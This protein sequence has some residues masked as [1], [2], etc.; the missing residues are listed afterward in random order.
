MVK[1]DFKD[2]FYY[3]SFRYSDYVITFYLSNL[4]GVESRQI[5]TIIYFYWVFS[6]LQ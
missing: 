5:R 3:F 2:I 4:K 1:L 6:I